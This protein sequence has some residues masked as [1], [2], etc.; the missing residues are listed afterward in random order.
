[1]KSILTSVFT[2]MTFILLSFHH[3]H[4]SHH[5]HVHHTSHKTSEHTTHPYKAINIS[6]IHHNDI[7]SYKHHN[8][9]VFYYLLMNNETNKYDTIKSNSPSELKHK[10]SKVS[11]DSD[12]DISMLLV[13]SFFIPFIIL[14]IIIFI[15]NLK[16]KK[17]E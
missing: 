17:S 13:F 15:N 11:T 4:H 16:N 7:H 8:R 14:M 10:V 3:S 6:D 9:I 5:S 2:L 12:N 1:M